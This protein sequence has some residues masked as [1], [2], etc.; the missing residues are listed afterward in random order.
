MI[1]DK[2]IQIKN[3]FYMLSYAFQALRKSN[4]AQIAAEE[5]ENIHDLFASILAK[6]IAAQL[7]RGLYKEYSEVSEDSP[8]LRGKLEMNGTIEHK[9]NT[10]RLLPCTHDEFSE[11]NILNKILKSTSVVLLSH[12]NVKRQHKVELKRLLLFF[13]SVDEVE[14]K[15]V[16]WQALNFSKNN[17]NYKMLMNICYF[18]AQGLLISDGSGKF[19]MADFLDDGQMSRLYEKFILEF[20]RYHFKNIYANPTQIAWDVDDGIIE[21]LP[22]MKTDIMLRYKGKTLIIDAKYYTRTMQYNPLYNSATLH[23]NNMYQIYSYVKNY[24]TNHNGD[25]AGMLLYAQTDEEVQPDKDYMISGN[26]ISVKTLDLNQEF[27]FIA[28]QLRDI[29][30]DYLGV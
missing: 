14:L 10:R 30:Y 9:L 16:S 26:K 21:F 5:F 1:K 7:K 6:G 28:K 29:A 13:S 8:V 17:Q 24:D 2:S 27:Q 23:S 12:P 20:Y 18:V 25:V 3:I 22:E 11:N 15:K 19:K 4:F